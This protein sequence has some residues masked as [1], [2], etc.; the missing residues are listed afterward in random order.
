[1]IFAKHASTQDLNEMEFAEN[2][3]PEVID[4]TD[5][6]YGIRFDLHG[7]GKG[8]SAYKLWPHLVH[9]KLVSSPYNVERGERGKKSRCP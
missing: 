5:H 4:D 2:Y 9:E 8:Y 6:E 7:S 1:M 3:Y